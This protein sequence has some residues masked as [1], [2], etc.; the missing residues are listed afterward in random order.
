MWKTLWKTTSFLFEHLFYHKI[1]VTM[2]RLT[3]QGGETVEERFMRTRQAKW[4]A[5]NL[6]TAATKLDRDEYGEFR[7]MCAAEGVT[8]YAVIGQLV[9]GWMRQR[10]MRRQLSDAVR[11]AW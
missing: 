5:A 8:P 3:V 11:G 7:A 9:R 1:P 4:D 10:R 6:A 2:V